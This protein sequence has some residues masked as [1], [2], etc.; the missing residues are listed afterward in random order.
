MDLSN[1]Q[2]HRLGVEHRKVQMLAVETFFHSSMI[3]TEAVP[4]RMQHLYYSQCK[5]QGV[6]SY[7]WDFQLAQSNHPLNVP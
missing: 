2:D 7:N 1:E 6:D 5:V 4:P 3:H